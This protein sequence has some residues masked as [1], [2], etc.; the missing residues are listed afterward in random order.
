MNRSTTTYWRTPEELVTIGFRRSRV[1]MMNEAHDA[2]RR[3]I[4]TRLIGQQILA[5][6]HQMGARYLAMEALWTDISIEAN[7]TRQLSS[8]LEGDYLSQPEM[9]TLIQKALDL[10]WTLVPYDLL[11]LTEPPREPS[12]RDFIN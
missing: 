3:C 6:A 10:G 5:P 9:H 4:R 12:S 7:N 1:V 11:N 8:E 2:L